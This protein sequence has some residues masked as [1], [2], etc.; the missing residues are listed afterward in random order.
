VKNLIVYDSVFGNTEKIAREMADALPDSKAIKV[1]SVKQSDL[2]GLKLMVIASPTRQFNATPD[3]VSFL[4]GLTRENLKGIKLAAFDTRIYM[5]FLPLRWI[6]DKGGYSDKIIADQL[7]QK[8]GAAEIPT[9]G[10]FVN[11]Q[12]GPLKKGELE[13]AV[14][15]IKSVVG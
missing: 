15:W 3:I 10:F 7:K 2:Q 8:S 11:G 6:V 13:R 14:A 5:P 4:A 12:E 9:E 1:G